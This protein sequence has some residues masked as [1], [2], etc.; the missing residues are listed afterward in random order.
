VVPCPGWHS[1]RGGLV[2]LVCIHVPLRRGLCRGPGS[3]LLLGACPSI[4]RGVPMT[5]TG[6]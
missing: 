4:A 5:W 6:S 1:R 3:P 2:D